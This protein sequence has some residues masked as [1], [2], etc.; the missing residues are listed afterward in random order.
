M[1]LLGII[2][3]R[4]GSK[5]IRN[6]N[7]VNVYGKPLI[8]YTIE[9]ALA[10]ACFDGLVVTSD[11]DAI[12]NVASK[13][14][15]TLLKRPAELATDTAGSDGVIE[16]ALKVCGGNN[17]FEL[18]MLL[19]P[20]SPL[21]SAD[22]IREALHLYKETSPAMVM[23]VTKLQDGLQKAFKRDAQGFLTGVLSKDAPFQR[24]Q[25]LPDLFLP[26]GAIYL[27][28]RAE[29]IKDGKLPRDLIV[30]YEMPPQRSVDID[31]EADLLIFENLL[32]EKTEY[33]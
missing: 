4:G 9:A 1:R 16:H 27:C 19:Q 10:S 25:D 29:F 12:L 13:Y 6:K 22:D 23:S 32:K 7:I 11:D 2:P 5:G 31:T 18:L 24:R 20:T 33:V 28:A 30:P 17:D 8:S 3:A 14:P 15:V 26:N 21:R